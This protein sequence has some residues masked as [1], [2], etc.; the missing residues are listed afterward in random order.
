MPLAGRCPREKP[1]RRLSPRGVRVVRKDRA[2][3]VA[4]RL[5][6]YRGKEAARL[7][8]IAGGM[9]GLDAWPSSGRCQDRP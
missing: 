4:A 9:E 6:P 5:C 1:V 3:A 8:E 2:R 7:A